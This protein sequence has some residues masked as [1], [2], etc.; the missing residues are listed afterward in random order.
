MIK[1]TEQNAHKYHRYMW[2]W[3]AR[4]PEAVGKSHWPGWLV[5]KNTNSHCFA[6]MLADERLGDKVNHC[7]GSFAHCTCCPI[8][9]W[10]EQ[11]VDGTS[12]CEPA[13]IMDDSVFDKWQSAWYDED[14]SR[15]AT[16]IS[17]M[18]WE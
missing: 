13:C 17:E 14:I 5:I 15:H 11:V 9:E 2:R 12:N 18:E 1:V 7:P 3:L 4:H 8:K 10:R 16:I 6:C